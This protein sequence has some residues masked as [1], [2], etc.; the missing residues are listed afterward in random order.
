MTGSEYPAARR[1]SS[2][3][4]EHFARHGAAARADGEER[5]AAVPDAQAI[6]ALIDAAFWASLHREEGYVP[7]VSLAFLPPGQAGN[8]LLFERGLPLVPGVLARVAPAVER[9]GIHL[10][11]WHDGDDLYVWGA[12]RALPSWCFVLEVAAP[13]LLVV[14]HRRGEES[15]KFVNVMVLEGEQVKLVD[16]HA[17]SLPDCPPLLTSLLGFDTPSSW[18]DSANVLVRLAV[19]MRAHGRGGLLLVVPGGTTYWRQSIVHPIAYSVEPPLT[20]LADLVR[21]PDDRRCVPR[22]QEAFGRAVEA[23]S[24]LTAVDGATVLTDRYELLAFGGKIARRDGWPQVERVAVT[25]PI[26]GSV[27]VTVPLGARWHAPP[28][29][30]AVRARSA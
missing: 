4:H 8:A 19:S 14:K 2:R 22:W 30:R 25:E 6:E 15:G 28:V 11:V 10:G 7:K 20:E 17:S 9:P 23:V 27:L 13:G 18:V 26:E 12:T 16:E 24:G 21:E 1:V 3:V 29:G 5:L